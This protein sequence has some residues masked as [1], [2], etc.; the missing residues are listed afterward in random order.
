M[1]QARIAVDSGRHL[2]PHA[3][4]AALLEL[5]TT[6]APHEMGASASPSSSCNGLAIRQILVL[7]D[8]SPLAD[9]ALPYAVAVAKAFPARITLL[10]VLETG[11]GA[12]SSR[13]VD[14][15]EWEFARAE[16]SAHLNALAADLESESVRATVE[17][18]QGKPA[19]QISH[20]TK[21][22]QVDLIVLAS[23]GE[24]GAGSGH[25][26]STAQKVIAAADTSV[27]I[28]PAREPQ[29]GRILRVR[30]RSI[31][32][33]LDCSQRAECILPT[34]MQLARGHDADLI[35]AHVVSEPEVPRRMAAS[36]EDL[37]LAHELTERNRASAKRYLKE[38]QSR[39]SATGGHVEVRMRVSRQ[40]T[41]TLC[42]LGDEEGVDLVVLSAH[43]STG[44]ANQ[45]YGGVAARFLQESCKPVLIV[46]DLASTAHGS[47]PAGEAARE[48]PGH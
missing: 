8:G 39:L 38:V 47:G 33:A 29:V 9:C 27:L 20:F 17:I 34:A 12:D 48:Q 28:V 13:G 26:G 24:G 43:G 44:D 15:L 1:T 14:L 6:R 36:E 30:F 22:R 42:D 31:L 18:V 19:E 25:L 5:E 2:R 37:E 21:N 11:R 10:R 7:L 3:A 46:Q 40:R 16:A 45:H 23:H 4:D 41:Q 35:L 32:V